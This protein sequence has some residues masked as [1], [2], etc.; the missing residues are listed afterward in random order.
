MKKFSP[1]NCYSNIYRSEESNKI[2]TFL[3][4]LAQT[5]W[6]EQT[7]RRHSQHETFLHNFNAINH[8]FHFD[9]HRQTHTWI[10]VC[11]WAHEI[12]I[13]ISTEHLGVIWWLDFVAHT[14]IVEEHI[15]AQRKTHVTHTPCCTSGECEWWMRTDIYYLHLN[16]QCLWFN[17]H[18][19]FQHTSTFHE[20]L[21]M[22][23]YGCVKWF[24]ASLHVRI[25]EINCLPTSVH[26]IAH[27]GRIVWTNARLKEWLSEC[28]IEGMFKCAA[29]N[30]YI[31]VWVCYLKFTPLVITGKS[32]VVITCGN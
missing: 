9:T 25:M 20:S 12:L 24:C 28:W 13:S 5:M 23:I 3:V 1:E 18:T 14:C 29:L 6:Y 4:N 26:L 17:R 30:W 22:Y 19:I 8:K 11:V 32:Q 7:G 10:Y 27:G 16:F 21:Y 15:E 31:Y 2:C